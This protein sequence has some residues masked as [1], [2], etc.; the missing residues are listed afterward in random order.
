M[1]VKYIPAPNAQ[2][3]NVTFDPERRNFSGH[4][5]TNDGHKILL[6]IGYGEGKPK[7]G[8]NYEALRLLDAILHAPENQIIRNFEAMTEAHFRKAIN[9]Y[10]TKVVELKHNFLKTIGAD[11]ESDESKASIAESQESAKYVASLEALSFEEIKKVLRIQQ[12]SIVDG[13]Y[14]IS[15]GTFEPQALLIGAFLPTHVDVTPEQIEKLKA[16]AGSTSECPLCAAGIPHPADFH[17]QTIVDPGEL[18]PAP[19]APA[20]AARPAGHTLH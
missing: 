13:G 5:I 15:I 1:T 18:A 3:M 12:I 7:F 11:L 20:P 2:V 6:L 10:S 8:E 17:P 4:H 19:A 9:D 14:K 16:M